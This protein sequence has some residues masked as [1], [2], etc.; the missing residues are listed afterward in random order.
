MVRWQLIMVL[1]L[2]IGNQLSPAVMKPSHKV[3]VTKKDIY[4]SD[5]NLADGKENRKERETKN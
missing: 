1:V 4:L 5:D 2:F 3:K